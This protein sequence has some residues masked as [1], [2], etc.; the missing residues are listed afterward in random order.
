MTNKTLRRDAELNRQ[1]LLEAAAELFRTRGLEITLDDVAEHAGVGVGTAYRRFA[2]KDELIDALLESR[3]DAMVAMAERGL[4]DPD[5]WDGL[6]GYIVGALELQVRDRG[7]KEVLF[8]PGRG[9]KRVAGAKSRLAPVVSRLA[10]RAREAG[11]VRQDF[12]TSDIPMIYLM[13]GTVV[14]FSRDAEP[15]LYQRY[16]AIL[17]EGI[18]AGG[19]PP[20][21]PV[22][23]L[24]IARFQE[25]MAAYKSR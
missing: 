22:P 7:L 18:R 4:E 24:D 21:L 9:R 17:L 13:L 25:A 23:A 20:E 12:D 15:E 5:P 3:I 2:N 1:R 10:A 19:Q 14:D 11:V 16:L 8:A 6:V